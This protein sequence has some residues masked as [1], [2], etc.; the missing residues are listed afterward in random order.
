MPKTFS[1]AEKKD[2]EPKSEI[3][4]SIEQAEKS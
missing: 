2:K 1:A 3:D 4:L